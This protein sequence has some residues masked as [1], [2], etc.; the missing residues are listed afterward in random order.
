MGFE[1]GYTSDLARRA[2][3]STDHSGEYQRRPAIGN[4]FHRPSIALLYVL[5]IAPTGAGASTIEGAMCAPS[6]PEQFGY[7]Q[8][9]SLDSVFAPAW[10]APDHFVRSGVEIF[11][12]HMITFFVCL[13]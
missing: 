1:A 12:E 13:V 10:S 9:H 4:S 2:S 5:L 3:K 8:Q 6:R 7:V 11:D